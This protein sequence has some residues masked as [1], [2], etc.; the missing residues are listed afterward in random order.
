MAANS[1]IEWT[2][3]T[4]NPWWGCEPVSPGCLNC[5]ARTLATRTGHAVWGS[6]P[7]AYRFFSAKHFAEPLKWDADAGK[8]GR[9]ARVFCGSMCD[10]FQRH[11]GAAAPEKHLSTYRGMV[12]D[13]IDRTPNMIWL[14]LTKRPENFDLVPDS[15]SDAWPNNAWAMTTICNQAEADRNVPL[16]LKCP[17]AVRGVSVEPMLG[18]VNL[19]PYLVGHED[20]GVVMGR[21]VGTCVG[22]TPPIDWVICGPETGPGRR[23]CYWAA[24]RSLRDQCVASG[25]KFFLKRGPNG[26]GFLDGREWREFPE[27]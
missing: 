24:V 2:D 8:L 9:K 7:A 23:P 27:C 13:L 5:Y 15:W 1:K 21:P 18:W 22:Y 6:D 19:S 11:D 10:I 20:N 25:V 14:L 26:D 16:L 4:F 17:S 12:F 3:H